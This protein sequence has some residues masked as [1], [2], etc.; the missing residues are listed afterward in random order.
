MREIVISKNEAGQRL[1]K[2]LGKYMKLAGKSFF[3]KM[4]RKKNIT[5]NGKKADGSEK[6]EEGDSVKLFL[7]DETIDKFREAAPEI[8]YPTANLNIIY[9]DEDVILINKPAGMLSQKAEAD[10]VS[11]VEYLLGYLMK[12]GDVTKE[13]L[14]TF[15]PGVCNRLDRNTSGIVICGKSLKGLQSMS[16]MLKERTLDKYY[17]CIVKG[18]MKQGAT[19]K[20]YLLKDEKTNQVKLFD[21]PKE[22]ASY[23]CTSYEPI[24]GNRNCTLVRVKLVTGRSHQ[25][26]AHLASVGHPILGDSKYGDP[27]AN[28]WVRE[29]YQVKRQL[30]HSTELQIPAD[31]AG[32]KISGKKVIA[33]LPADICC[34]VKGEG[35]SWAHGE[36]EV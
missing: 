19:L 20:G 35:L 26:R 25:I 15:K 21:Q 2:F 27:A 10:D 13:S 14:S 4:M 23:I 1:D 30:L 28:R 5:L 29:Q 7:A 11:L 17:T 33:K 8:H 34:V 16:S 3:Y 18:Q 32:M 9:E 22:G 6:L 24:D 36:P 12:K 31:L